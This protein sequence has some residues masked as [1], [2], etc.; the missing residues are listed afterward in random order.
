MHLFVEA[1]F[2]SEHF[3][4]SVRKLG[5]STEEECLNDPSSYAQAQ[6]KPQWEQAMTAEYVRLLSFK[7]A[8]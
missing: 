4:F 7:L 5:I 8:L 3:Q 6:G 2:N 1:D